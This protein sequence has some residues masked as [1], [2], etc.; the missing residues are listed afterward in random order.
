MR[1]ILIIDK[2]KKKYQVFQDK[3]EEILSVEIIWANDS[4]SALSLLSILPELEFIL[5]EGNLRNQESLNKIE[6]YLIQES[7]P[8]PLIL[9][10][11]DQK[12]R[13]K[14]ITVSDDLDSDA[15]FEFAKLQITKNDTLKNTKAIPLFV[16]IGIVFLE[17]YKDTPFPVDFYLRIKQSAEDFQYIKRLHANDILSEEDRARFEKHKVTHLYILKSDYKSFLSFSLKIS[18]QRKKD[19]PNEIVIKSS[20]DYHLTRESLSLL[21]ID[22]ETQQLVEN[23]ISSME[24]I[25]A[26]NESIAN[27]L[28]LLQKNPDGYSYI[29]SVLL[30]M[31]ST[32]VVAQFDWNSRL[33]KEKIC[34]VAFFHDISIPD[35]RL[36]RINSNEEL[37]SE[38]SDEFDFATDSNRVNNNKNNKNN[39]K[40]SSY[41]IEQVQNHALNSALLIEQFNNI[42]QG[43]SLIVKEHHGSKNGIGFSENLS[44]TLQPLSILFLIIESFVS[45][46]LKI[47]HP[48]KE[49]LN[50]IIQ[51]LSIKYNKGSYKKV[52]DALIKTVK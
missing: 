43:V 29:H 49:D 9:L 24:K 16:G 20:F 39:K 15:F 27:F 50:R 17:Q 35:D 44:I 19:E 5:I 22:E 12:K 25:I 23:N 11:K 48:N 51:D 40:Y 8:I 7:S 41:E 21:G 38:S 30:A 52:I 14:A 36:T 6:E 10:S 2:D 42:P 47:Q 46:F 1:Q 34:F 18:L 3:F 28:T 31:I 37:L 33:I 13:V 4:D 32:K 26:K 45:E